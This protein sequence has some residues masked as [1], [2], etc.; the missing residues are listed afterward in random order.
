MVKRA[1][2]PLVTQKGVALIAVVSALTFTAII[3]TEFTTTTQVD[4]LG[5]IDARD[6]MQAE[7]LARSSM[8]LSE[9]IIRLQQVLDSP[10]VRDTLGEIQITDYADLF[11]SAFG[12]TPQ[13]L[14]DQGLGGELGKSFGG[15]VGSFGVS[16]TT[17]D[18]LINLNCANGKPEYQQLTYTL[19]EALYYF[20]A[21][22]PLFQDPDADGWRRDRRLQ[23]QAIF[24][25]IDSDRSQAS[26]PGEPPSG[27]TEDYG[28]ENLRDKYKPK[29]NYL[30][31]VDELKLVRGV[32][33]RF[34]TLFGPSFTVYGGCKLNI[35]SL[36]DPRIIAAILYL[37]AKDKED[38][39]LRDGALLWYHA[40]A[41]A[42][43]RQNGFAFSSPQDFVDFVKDREGALGASVAELAAAAGASGG[44]PPPV[45]IPGVP[46]GIDLGLELDP[47]EVG[48]VV[49]VGPQRTYRV[50]AWG[51]TSRNVILNPVRRTLTA[52]WDSA[53]VNANQ[54][55]QD[56][57][58]RNGAWIYLRQ[59]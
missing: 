9:L 50:Q 8:N 41:V 45:Q 34:Y 17:D 44:A 11:M 12:G 43:A 20:P 19:L 47:A 31:S 36:E 13:E 4:E 2:K 14:E 55:S 7:F 25:F 53:N 52:I 39:V 5:A 42:W 26:A 49:R 10:Q 23:T 38:P 56:A 58:A 6:Q 46:Q 28:Y 16:I 40:T 51:E 27:A 37:T 48:K 29:N 57:K 3:A 59:E 15:E 54:R 18:G 22:D 1:R 21:F 32:D 24:D 33:E 35:R 30:D